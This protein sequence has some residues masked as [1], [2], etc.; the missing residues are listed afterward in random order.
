MLQVVKSQFTV[1]NE[2]LAQIVTFVL[3]I[4]PTPVVNNMQEQF[5]EYSRYCSFQYKKT[6]RN[7]SAQRCEEQAMQTN[8]L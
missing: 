4:T 6:N 7:L 8:C 5:F 2:H 3:T 1:C